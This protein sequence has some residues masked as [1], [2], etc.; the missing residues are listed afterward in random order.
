VI[1]VQ[2]RDGHTVCSPCSKRLVRGCPS[3]SKP[4][5]RI[6]CMTAEKI[7]ES[8]TMS[9]KYASEGCTEMLKF[10]KLEEHEQSRCKY[11]TTPCPMPH[12]CH[13]GAKLTIPKHLTEEHGVQEVGTTEALCKSLHHG[14]DE[15][16]RGGLHHCTSSNY[17]MVKDKHQSVSL[18]RVEEV[19]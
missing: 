19:A 8:L 4:I 16:C 3:C 14:C 10:N 1:L 11:V 2:C 5:G 15:C 12:C 7:L 17:V 6:R 9:C 13:E 18:V